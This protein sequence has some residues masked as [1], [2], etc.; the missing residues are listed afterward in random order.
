[1]TK[2]EFLKA[3]DRFITANSLMDKRR[4]YLTALS[5]GADSVALTLALK[6]LGYNVE[7]VH[8]NFRLRGEESDRDEDFCKTLCGGNGI[9]LHIVHFDTREFAKLHKISIEMAA[10]Q[11]RYAYFEQLRNDTGSAGICV[12]HHREDSVETLLINL[13]RGTGING[14]TGIAAKNGNIIRP[15]LNVA[16]GDIEK[17]L[18]DS[19][20]GFVTDSTNLVDDVTRNKIRLNLMPI[21]RSINPSA[22]KDIAATAMRLAE[23]AKVFNRAI[24]KDTE[25]IS[26]TD[27]ERTAIDIE[28]LRNCCSPEYTLF[29]ILS[30][31]RFTPATIE[32]IHERL[33]GEVPTGKVFSSPSH[34]LLINRGF[35]IIEPQGC[36]A[37]R[38]M[39]IP[40]CGNYVLSG[41]VKIR[42]E[43]IE[44]DGNG[45]SVSKEKRTATLDASLVKFPLKIRTT[46]KGDWFIPFGMKG[47]KLVSDYLTDRKMCLFDKERQLVVE[48]AER[49]IVWLVNE[50]ADNRF[51]IGETTTALITITAENG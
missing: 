12:G 35:I 4:K 13:I 8:C 41:G 11:L 32:D 49:R 23:A 48:D 26:A 9:P 1:M 28:K 17:F 15:L 7:A 36:G 51:R 10:R 21:I 33:Q 34:R 47:R 14:M 38:E 2:T 50:R 39:K 46:E 31:F 5:G 24:A 25:E 22:D 29:S 16:R 40:E 37:R 42:I 3:V 44:T 20:A 19:G 30:K 6:G 43:K 45:F 18:S 27:G